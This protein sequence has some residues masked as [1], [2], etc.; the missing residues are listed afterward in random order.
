[1][2]CANL[3]A[4]V[5]MRQAQIAPN[6]ERWRLKRLPALSRTTNLLMRARFLAR[7]DQ[8][9]DDLQPIVKHAWRSLLR[10]REIQTAK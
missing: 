8:M 5:S 7:I 6:N 4:A 9:A 1:M 2:R 10:W 3:Y